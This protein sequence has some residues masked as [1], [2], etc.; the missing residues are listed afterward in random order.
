MQPLWTLYCIGTPYTDHKVHLVPK[1]TD[2]IDLR[3]N[4]CCCVS[5]VSGEMKGA[6]CYNEAQKLFV[7][8]GTP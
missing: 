7:V 4:S 5:S 1:I 3:L 2:S 6:A 8:I